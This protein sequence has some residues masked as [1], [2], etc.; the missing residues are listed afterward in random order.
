M[1]TQNFNPQGM[2][3]QQNQQMGQQPRMAEPPKM[4]STKDLSYLTDAMAWE[5]D[6]IKK[7]NHFA[8][9]MQDAK[10]KNLITK[11][12]QL[13]QKHYNMLLKHLNPANAQPQFKQ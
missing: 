13:H 11:S 4:I 8:N 7:F 5:L 1:Q 6:I 10:S 2:Q 12:C 9:E 3:N